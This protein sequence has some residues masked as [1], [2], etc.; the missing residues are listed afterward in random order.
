MRYAQVGASSVYGSWC[1]R[2]GTKP[3]LNLCKLWELELERCSSE[4]RSND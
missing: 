1:I 4:H 2:A 3:L